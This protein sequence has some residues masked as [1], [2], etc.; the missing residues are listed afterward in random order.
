VLT[1]IQRPITSALAAANI[2][3]SNPAVIAAWVAVLGTVVA[4]W[5]RKW[6][7]AR[8]VNRA[9]LA[10]INRLLVVLKS[11]EEFWCGRVKANDTQHVLLPFTHVVYSE[12]VKNVG[13]LRGELVADVVQ[14]YGYVEFLNG[15][16][17][18]RKDYIAA[19]KSADFDHL[20][21]T[22]LQNCINLG[23]T[24]FAAHFVSMKIPTFR[25]LV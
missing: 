5:V 14:F 7:E 10:E 13:M 16:Q 4:Y 21:L 25:F 15:L 19:G 24:S 8:T 22:A 17:A 9:I 20:Y 18:S 6:Y 12:Q 3:W 23:E 1:N 11:H 2:D